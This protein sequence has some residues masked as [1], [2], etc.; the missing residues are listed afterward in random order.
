MTQRITLGAKATGVPRNAHRHGRAGM[1]DNAPNPCGMRRTLGGMLQT[2]LREH[3]DDL[4]ARCE[5]KAK[6]R[7]GPALAV[8]PA[9]PGLSAFV[10]QLAAILEVEHEAPSGVFATSATVEPSG[11]IARSAEGHGAVLQRSGYSVDQLVHSYGDVCQAISDYVVEHR[12]NIPAPE[13]RTLNRCLD[14]AMAEAVTSH[15]LARQQVVNWRG[16]A[17]NGQLTLFAREHRRLADVA[18][19]AFAAIR[20]GSVGPTGATATV[21]DLALQDLCALTDRALPE[22]R[23]RSAS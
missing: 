1:C 19:G 4:L 3:R 11:V 21:L 16:E 7:N 23:L 22:L 17:L 18:N 12:L 20:S 6:A 14:E 8:A 15:G 9:L 2:I 10:E 5:T 13:F